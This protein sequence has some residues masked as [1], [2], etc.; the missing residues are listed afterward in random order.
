MKCPECGA[1]IG[2][3]RTCEKCGKEVLPPKGLEVE[4]KEFRISELLDIKMTGRVSSGKPVKRQAAAEERG[5]GV[6][7]AIPSERKLSGKKLIAVAA[8]IVIIATITGFYLLRFLM[9]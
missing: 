8:A 4:Y 2:S 1:E 5:G 3:G 6:E 7:K 9:K